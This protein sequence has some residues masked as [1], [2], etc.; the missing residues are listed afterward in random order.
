[1]RRLSVAQQVEAMSDR[2]QRS[3]VAAATAILAGLVLNQAVIQQLMRQEIMRESVIYQAILAEGEAKGRAEGK[4]EGKREVALN[5]LK[6]G[7]NVEQVAAV[8]EL[9]IA[10]IAQL[11]P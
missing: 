8:T 7:M 9:P 2:Q 1:M 5:L 3:D 6:L 4:A 10:A 11:Q